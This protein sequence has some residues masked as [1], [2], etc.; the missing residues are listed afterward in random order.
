MII[1]IVGIVISILGGGVIVMLLWN[2]IVTEIFSDITSINYWQAIGLL[3]L[4][5]ILFN[6]THGVLKDK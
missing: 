1:R 3:V 4:C 2:G 6:N 5:D